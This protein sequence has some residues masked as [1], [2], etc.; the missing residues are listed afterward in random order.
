MR[1]IYEIAEQN[2]KRINDLI[3][4]GQYTTLQDFLDISITNQLYLEEQGLGR[5]Q[6]GKKTPKSAARDHIVTAREVK[7]LGRNWGKLL[8]VEPVNVETLKTQLMPFSNRIFPAKVAV[9]V[10]CNTLGENQTVDYNMYAEVVSRVAVGLGTYLK[11][12][13][14]KQRRSF[15]LEALS[16]GL[17]AAK[18]GDQKIAIRRFL[19]HVVGGSRHVGEHHGMLLSLGLAGMPMEGK[20]GITPDGLRFA[21]LMSPILDAPESDYG[22][23]KSCLSS[24]EAELYMKI[25]KDRLPEEGRTI[26]TLED[27]VRS[28]HSYPEICNE[29]AKVINLTQGETN[30]E[31]RVS[32]EL[33]RMRELGLI[34]GRAEGLKTYY[35]ISS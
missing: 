3:R 32:T 10:L 28:K 14:K 23:L 31:Q 2:Y 27:I 9:R 1:I 16:T 30:V 19:E 34:F 7:E 12:I 6:P 11:S 22:N 25:V 33:A 29:F 35:D 4:G 26:E 21:E 5:S 15:R 8:T 18:R 17:P 24:E 20:F 13:D